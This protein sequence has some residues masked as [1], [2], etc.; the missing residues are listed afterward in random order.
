MPEL[1]ESMAELRTRRSFL[2]EVFD[3]S[4]WESY[5][6]YFD[7]L[8]AT[9]FANS[10]E[11][12]EW[13]EDFHELQIVYND[14]ASW[15]HINKSRDTTNEEF[16]AT[17]R[18]FNSE[19]EPQFA[20]Y[21][22][23][24]HRKL[25]DSEFVSDLE[26]DEYGRY[27]HLTKNSLEL[28]HPENVEL[29]AQISEKA[30]EF[31]KI[32]AS[33]TVHFQD[34]E[35]TLT[36][37]SVFLKN[38]DRA[39]REEAWRLVQDRKLADL[40]EL[41]H[42]FSDLV[43][44]RHKIAVNAGFD[45]YRDFMFRFLRRF[46]YSA[47][48]CFEF[49]RSVESVVVP[50]KEELDQYRKDTLGLSELRPW[51]MEVDLYGRDPLKPFEQVD[52]L[53]NGAIRILNK[54]NPALGEKIEIM[55]REGHLDLESR[56]GKEPTGYNAPLLETHIPF[57]FM[58]AVGSQWDVVVLL[59]E[60][61]HAI[62]TFSTREH[63]IIDY[64]TTNAEVAELASMSMELMSMDHWDEFYTNEEDLKRAKREQISRIV[65]LLPRTMQG[66]A[67]QHWAYENPEHTTGQRID[68]W[69]ELDH[70]FTRSRVENY[71]GLPPFQKTGW[72]F[73]HIFERPF[74]FIEYAIAQLGALQ[75]WRNFRQD[76]DKAV[77]DYLAALELG[78]SVPM[79]QV[80]ERAG[81]KFDFSKEM[82]SSLM[83]FLRSEWERVK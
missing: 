70:R 32:S 76:P 27:L 20:S 60:G 79:S 22:D 18:R 53:V 7:R 35:R 72:Q 56:K 39:I 29:E 42:I 52:D 74:Y 31:A 23:M 48:D 59:H 21:V 19:I 5:K 50:F 78:G 26:R 14:A 4:R 9:E 57:I 45:N 24:M 10:R 54:I 41:N 63:K 64:K 13:I 1:L 37:M 83:E 77:K 61:G 15:A 82:V 58:N 6:P 33:H 51:D 62:H 12:R 38:P 40:D 8:L 71:D 44:I 81:A 49:H 67:F 69:L 17:Y 73:Y 3:T 47:E 28:F 66:D 34:K 55:R 25:V 46:E 11:L 2:P 68:K 43:A 80:Y 30:F 65:G 36:Q 75:I 16:L